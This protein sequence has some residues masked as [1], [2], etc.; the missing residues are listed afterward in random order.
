MNFQ[1]QSAK[2]N[3]L[4]LQQPLSVCSNL[5]RS[6]VKDIGIIFF[7]RNEF[8]GS[9]NH[10]HLSISEIYSNINNLYLHKMKKYPIFAVANFE[11]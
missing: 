5:R 6:L 1:S 7:I 10:Y 3:N 4:R 2:S 11:N 8:R 9:N